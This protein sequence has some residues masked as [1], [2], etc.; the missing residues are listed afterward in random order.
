MEAPALYY[1]VKSEVHKTSSLMKAT[2]GA[3]PLSW[4]AYIVWD[5]SKVSKEN[6]EEDELVE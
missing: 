4:P 1:Q 2:D 6:N 5:C 3:S